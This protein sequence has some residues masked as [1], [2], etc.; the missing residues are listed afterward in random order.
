MHEKR[1]SCVDV[2]RWR[3]VGMQDDREYDI[4]QVGMETRIDVKI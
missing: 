3:P 4:R 1:V 2:D